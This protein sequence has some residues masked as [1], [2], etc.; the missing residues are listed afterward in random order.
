MERTAPIRHPMPARAKRTPSIRKSFMVSLPETGA[1]EEAAEKPKDEEEDERRGDDGRD[2]APQG[3]DRFAEPLA[4][5]SVFV[6][7]GSGKIDAVHI[8][9][10]GPAGAIVRTA[11][12]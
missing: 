2:E 12:P 4:L 6:V 9:V 1:S 5:Q 3:A 8:G 7:A 10:V 11:M